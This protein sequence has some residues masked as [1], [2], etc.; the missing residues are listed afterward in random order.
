[1]SRPA[2]RFDVLEAEL[3][4]RFAAGVESEWDDFD[5]VAR[6]VFAYQV[7][8]NAA[9]AA[10]AAG[11]G[12]GPDTIDDWRE[13][14][15]VP[16]SAF[17][18]LDLVSGDATAVER[19]FRT[20]GTSGGPANRGRHPVL[21]LELYRA[22][23]LPPL[24]TWLI[25]EGGPIRILS[26]I[27]DPDDRPDS[28]LACMMGFARDA[29]GAPGSA[30]FADADYELDVAGFDRALGESEADDGPVLLAGTAFAFAHWLERS[31]RE[32]VLPE[33]SRLMETGGFKGRS[34]EVPRPELYARL[35]E[36]LGIAEDR[37]VNEY[38]MTEMLSQFWE[39]V[40]AGGVRR[41]L[42]PPWVR[43]RFLDPLT[44]EE[45]RPGAPGLLCHLDLANLGSVAAVLT[46]DVGVPIRGGFRVLGRVPGAE[47][48][49]CSLALEELL[50]GTGS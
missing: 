10:F 27:P 45:A 14:P 39:P 48:R 16:A 35:G 40:L 31:S 11:R 18:H 49:G 37:I 29:F 33:G 1:M 26:L 24:R 9:Y 12:V 13:I 43:T 3:R 4:E 47:P 19:V 38:G 15:P 32:V 22:A 30:T 25:P 28:S 5:E 41:H 17:K 20:S 36:R 21:S 42:A 7:S 23:A 44:L 6:R 34:Q 8:T 50:E 2:P 46:E